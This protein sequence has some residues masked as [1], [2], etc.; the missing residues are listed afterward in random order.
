MQHLIYT[1]NEIMIDVT[2]CRLTE[3]DK[4]PRAF[5]EVTDL[6]VAI[7]MAIPN[8]RLCS[9]LMIFQYQ[10]AMDLCD[11]FLR[12]EMGTTK[13]IT[14]NEINALTEI[15]NI[16]ICAYLNG[17]AKLLNVEFMPSPPSVASDMVGSI[18]ESIAISVDELYEYA[19]I[20]ETNFIHKFGKNKGHFLFILDNESKE[21]IFK[22]FKVKDA[23]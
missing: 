2:E 8:R 13:R 10:S 18:L 15:G 21:A 5:G 23:K 11:M 16:C 19:V 17:L 6:V 3:V 12:K 7:N 4:I 22:V 14:K 1:N 20:I 9:I